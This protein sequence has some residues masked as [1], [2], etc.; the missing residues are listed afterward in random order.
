M[1][2][3][4]KRHF[5]TLDE[6]A[7]ATFAKRDTDQRQAD[8]D[9]ITK[10]AD[11]ADPVLYT[12]DDGIEIRKSDGKIV[13]ALAK[14]ADKA[15]RRATVA[16]DTVQESTLRK[17]AETDLAS[18]PGTLDE[19]VAMLKGI[20]TIPAGAARDAAMAALRAGDAAIAKAFTRTG[21]SVN[22]PEGT[23]QG[24]LDVLAKRHQEANPDETPAMAMEKVLGTAEGKR[25]YAA[26][27]RANPAQGPLQ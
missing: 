20:D 27:R 21:H 11:A 18:L 2:D 5:E 3:V 10:A 15:D 13:V 22:L 4:H 16:E 12:C 8:L 23:P 7:K 19:K 17:R 9:V 25:L 24:D 6:A 26:N 1:T 14:R